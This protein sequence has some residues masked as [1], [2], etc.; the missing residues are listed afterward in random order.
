MQ[1]FI[2]Y[3]IDA[4][5]VILL[6]LTVIISA[7]KGFVK[8]VISLVCVIAAMLAAF[9]FSEPAAVWCYD[10]IVSDIVVSKVEE[11]IDKGYDSQSVALTVGEIID[12]VP[13]FI[14]V[15]LVKLGIDINVLSENIT[16]LQL[17]TEDTAK[18]ISDEIIRPGIIVL[19]NL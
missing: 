16:K 8:C 5:L 1:F 3:G 7:R 15:Q 10:N 17:S 11:S 12:T 4:L 9:E 13:D 19:L 18:K 2:Q 6:I 14:G